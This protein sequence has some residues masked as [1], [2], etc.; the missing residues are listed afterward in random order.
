MAKT[1]KTR[2]EMI[3][4]LLSLRASLALAIYQEHIKGV[5]TDTSAAVF[6]QNEAKIAELKINNTHKNG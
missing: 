4:L 2:E 6:V 5:E 1:E 3:K